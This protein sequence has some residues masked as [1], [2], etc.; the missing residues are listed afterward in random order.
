MKLFFLK[1]NWHNLKDGKENPIAQ[2]AG[3]VEHQKERTIIGS[4]SNSLPSKSFICCLLP[5]SLTSD[6]M[7]GIFYF[8]EGQGLLFELEDFNS[9]ISL[10]SAYIRL[11]EYRGLL[12]HTLY[13]V[14]HK[15]FTSLYFWTCVVAHEGVNSSG[16][17]TCWSNNSY[18]N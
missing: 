14:I 10:N 12:A 17:M 1:K 7:Y 13:F 2:C 5:G 4:T 3:L 9:C 8:R 6:Y 18:F 16:K 11:F 15:V